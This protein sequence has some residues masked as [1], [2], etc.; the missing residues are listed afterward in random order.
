[1]RMPIGRRTALATLT[2]LASATALGLAPAAHAAPTGLLPTQLLST[3]TQN[4]LPGLANATRLG[5][6]TGSVL[7]LV[8]TVPRPDPS[9]E[10]AL[11]RA[12]HTPGN[13]AYRHFLTPAQFASRFGVPS[14]QQQAVRSFFTQGGAHVDSVSSAGDIYSVHGTTAVLGSL[15]HTSFGRYRI[16]GTTFVANTSAPVTPAS[17][18]IR[19]IVGLNTLQRFRTPAKAIRQQGTCL[20]STCI[21]GTT[22]QDLWKVYDQPATHTGAGQSMAIFGEGQTDG[23]ISDL[24]AFEAK[25]DLPQIPVTVKHPA[26]DTDFSDDSGHPEWNIDTQAASGMAPDADNLTLYFGSDLSDAD[27]A[28]V[29]SQFTD[30]A[31][32]PMQASASY[33]ECETVPVV[34]SI[35]A[36][37]LL[38]PSLPIGQG[39]GNN[40]DATLTQITQQA[41]AEGKTIFASTGDTGSSCPVVFASVIGAGNGVLN[42]GV[43]VTNSPASLPWVTAVGGTVL[44]TDGSGNRSREY[45]WAFSGG[46]STLFTPAPAYQIGT[47]N[48]DIPC[49]QPLGAT[50]RGI[51]DVSA[52]SGDVT[53]NGYDI[54]MSG[55]YTEGGGAGTSLS[56]PLWLGMWTRVQSAAPTAAGNGFANEQLYRVGNAAAS[57]SRDFF[58]VSSLDT[59]TGLPA[60]NGLYPTLPGW[61]YVTGFGTPKV[62]GLIQDIDG[63]S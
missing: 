56:S 37:P 31:T 4:V 28:K 52:Q 50:C 33:G 30:D 53:G 45:G 42:Q 20:G 44:Y 19:N 35:A 11:I 47:K 48:L 16:S 62:A 29:F 39:L 55:T 59:S 3:V 61:D 57:Y 49:L 22:P 15:L 7:H 21:G 27:V 8:V 23:V 18:K 10:R 41:A 2:A 40:S 63:V 54:V 17:L 13:A 14:T 5:A 9:G 60:T 25:F 51:A 6:D 34:S 1:M 36:N 46:G 12:E 58:D 24:R 32:G 43:P 38:N 26:G